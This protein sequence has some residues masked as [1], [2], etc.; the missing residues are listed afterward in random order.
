M[1]KVYMDCPYCHA[2]QTW[3][4]EDEGNFL[5]RC[6]DCRKFFMADLVKAIVPWEIQMG[7]GMYSKVQEELCIDLKS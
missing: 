3:E 5:F 4:T 6:G 2:R 7:N 1:M